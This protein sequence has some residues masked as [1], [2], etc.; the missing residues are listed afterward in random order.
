[1]YRALLL[2]RG[3]FC[4]ITV[5]AVGAVG[6]ADLGERVSVPGRTGVPPGPFGAALI[7]L[8]F[9]YVAA[10][11]EGDGLRLANFWCDL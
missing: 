1:M 9:D 10:L 3:H 11:R 6:V 5:A 4:E 2:H 7:Q 8:V